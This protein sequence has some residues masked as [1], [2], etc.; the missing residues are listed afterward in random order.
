ML[1]EAFSLMCFMAVYGP[2]VVF[3]VAP[4]LLL[5]TAA[6]RAVRA[7]GD[8]RLRGGG[9]GRGHR[10]AARDAVPAVRGLRAVARVDRRRPG[11]GAAGGDMSVL[12]ADTVS[13]VHARPRLFGIARRVL[14][15]AADADDVVQEAWIRWQESDRSGV[16]DPTAFLAT[17]TTR[18]ALNV[19][20]SARVRHETDFG[21][22]RC[23]TLVDPAADPVFG[24]ERR[25]ALAARPVDDPRAA[26]PDRA[27]RLRAAGG[28]RLPAPADRGRSSGS[29]RPTPASSSRARAA[30][31]RASRAGRSTRSSGAGWSTRSSPPADGRPRRLERLLRPAEASDARRRRLT[32]LPGFELRELATSRGTHQRD[33]R[34]QRPAAAAAARLPRVAR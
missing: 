7:P 15:S 26:V 30:T 17:T 13:F 14:G 16:R 24:A 1:G 34:R 33:G 2:P 4:W 28:V 21:A 23:S 10:G 5:G 11:A 6:E 31:S 32:P 8:V 19:G 29:A 9:A 25:E 18:L 3:L 12:D 22:A 20:Q 27:G